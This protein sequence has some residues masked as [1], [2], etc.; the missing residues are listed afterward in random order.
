MS[1]AYDE[2]AL[3]MKAKLFLSHAMD[4]DEPRDFDGGCGHLLLS[5]FWPRRHW[6]EYLPC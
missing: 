4:D 6:L 2:R 3:W 5:N 1:D